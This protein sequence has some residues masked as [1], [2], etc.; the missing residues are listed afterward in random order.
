MIILYK[1]DI[2]CK[3]NRI[4]G[5]FEISTLFQLFQHMKHRTTTVSS[6]LHRVEI[7]PVVRELLVVVWLI[8][9]NL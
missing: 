6:Y 8:D 3:S 9:G 7:R 2:Q 1:S 5:Q 4:A